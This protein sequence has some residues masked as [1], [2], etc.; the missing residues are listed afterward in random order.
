MDDPPEPVEIYAR[1]PKLSKLDEAFNDKDWTNR[2]PAKVR[3]FLFPEANLGD[4]NN[5]VHSLF[6]TSP[7]NPASCQPSV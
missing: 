2:L 3:G 6:Q 4:L 1:E 7:I 5:E